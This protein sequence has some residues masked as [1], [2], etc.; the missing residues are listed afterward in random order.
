[1]WRYIKYIPLPIIWYNLGVY[2][3]K[4]VKQNM[5]NAGYNTS[6]KFKNYTVWDKLVE[7]FIIRQ[8]ST[9]FIG[10]HSFIKGMISDNKDKERIEE[11]VSNMDNV[12]NDEIHPVY[13]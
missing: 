1:M 13:P 4:N 9:V 11:Y 10:G 5:F 6:Q 3:N 8:F 2:D 12:I 7:P